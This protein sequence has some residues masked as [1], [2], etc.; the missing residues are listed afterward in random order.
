M[1]LAW[2]DQVNFRSLHA[3]SPGIYSCEGR[4][5]MVKDRHINKTWAD[6][7][8]GANPSPAQASQHQGLGALNVPFLD[9][10]ADPSLAAA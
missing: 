2:L 6:L 1:D 5:R 10:S 3:T 4:N 7:P 8:D 9:K